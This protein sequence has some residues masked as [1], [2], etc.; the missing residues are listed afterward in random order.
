MSAPTV[1]ITG[2]ASGIGR[3]T[4]ERMLDDGAR[5]IGLDID[6]HRLKEAAH[7]LV[8]LHPV[9]CDL[10]DLDAVD[11]LGA[12]PWLADVGVLCNIAG[13]L[14]PGDLA[15]YD[16]ARFDRTVTVMQLAPAHLAH[17]VLPHMYARNHG[18]IVNMGSVYSLIGG[19]GKGGYVTAKGGL[20]SL[21]RQIALEGARR[22]VRAFTVCPG[23]VVS[24]LLDE[25]AA[26]EGEMLDIP[27]DVRY[28]Q[29]EAEMPTGKFVTPHDV[30]AVV[31]W[32]T[33]GAPMAMTGA[34]ISIDGGWTAGTVSGL[35]QRDNGAPRPY[36]STRAVRSLR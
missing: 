3:A 16:M 2:A 21:T 9:V 8:G 27:A 15:G 10:G 4:A 17:L 30:A 23:H 31:S 14:D 33:W 26:R 35:R 22:G 19:N 32:L 28:G 12:E 13:A 20:R 6:E 24:P 36:R 11:A 1:L 18:V 7:E 5:V 25:Q 34:D 29:L